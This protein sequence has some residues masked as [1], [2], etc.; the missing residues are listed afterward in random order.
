VNPTSENAKIST[1]SIRGGIMEAVY[2][3]MGVKLTFANSTSGGIIPNQI[4]FNR[5]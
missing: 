5:A 3:A 4:F 1:L 2:K